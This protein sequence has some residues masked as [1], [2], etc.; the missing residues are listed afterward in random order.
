MDFRI[1][2]KKAKPPASSSKGE[3]SIN[4][5]LPYVRGTSETLQWIFKS[6]GVH[7]FH[8]PFN[9]LRQQ[10]A[11]VKD[12]TA[13]L[14][15]GGV[16]DDI[17]CEQCQENYIGETARTLGARVKNHQSRGTSAVFEHCR[18][19]GHNINPYNV[20]VLTSKTTPCPSNVEF[21]RPFLP[22]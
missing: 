18:A 17:Q 3:R 20:K 13:K 1:P 15:K 8:K 22:E 11:H 21:T 4:V 10:V 2:K 12:R 7:V 19:T 14:K 5:G 9:S 6:H 16:V